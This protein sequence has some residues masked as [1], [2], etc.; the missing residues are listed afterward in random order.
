MSDQPMLS[1]V[2]IGRN[3]GERLIRCLRSVLSMDSGS[4]GSIDL[5]YV[6][7]AS[8]DSSVERACQLGARVIQVNPLRPCASVGRNAGWRAA[9]ANVILFLDGDTIL[10]PDFV[11][12]AKRELEDANVSV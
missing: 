7:S 8:T 3:E 9:R 1:V 10:A 2:V 6:D 4:E 12:H 5:I 11:R